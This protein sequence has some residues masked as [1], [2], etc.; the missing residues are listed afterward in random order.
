MV[1]YDSE[2]FTL[3]D[4][5]RC[6]MPSQGEEC[7]SMVKTWSADD[8]KAALM[9]RKRAQLVE[10]ALKAFLEAGYA[11]A[12]VNQIAAAAGVSI[13][14]L[15]RHFESKDEL[16]SAVMQA[17]CGA[18]EDG[19]Q[20]PAWYAAPPAEA[21]PRAGEE[22]LR[23]ALSPDQL[24]LHR[25][26]TRDAHRFP[27]LGRRYQ[28]QTTGNR[29][30]RFAGYLDLWTEREGWKV[31]DKRAAAQVFAALLKAPIYDEVL[32]GLRRPSKTEIVD[33]AREAAQSMLVLLRSGRL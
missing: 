14:T 26:V 7:A 18:A 20:A 31:R 22:Y 25:V 4:S 33:R 10:A 11:E 21:L 24:A 29:D 9:A 1:A 6:R 30:A 8:P 17:A 23:H 16:F 15:Y 5:K 28:E 32:L 19:E 2:R 3:Y 27:E 12:S 13:K